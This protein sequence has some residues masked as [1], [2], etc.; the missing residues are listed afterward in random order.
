MD[1]HNKNVF[2]TGSSRGIGYTIAETF[3]KEG[4][5]I[6]LN[7]RKEIDQSL[8]DGITQY[9]VTCAAVNG[10]IADFEQA[11]Q[12]LAEAEAA[13]GPIHIL[14]NNAGIT[15]DKLLLRMKPEDFESVIKINLTGT[16]NMTQHA[17]KKMMKLREGRIINLTSVVGL[18]GNIGQANYAA[19]KA[20]VIGFTKSAAR[21]GAA[22]G[23]TVNAIA[24]G[25]IE[26]EMT[27]VLSD[28]V[29]EQSIAVIPLQRF[30]STED[31]AHAAVFLAKSPYITG[32]VLS[33]D[34]GMAMQG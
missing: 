29:K 6:I 12:M 31:V 18:T 5:N 23:I 14:V 26:T 2:V 19:S 21:E 33:V 32:Q 30:G 8:I 34:G 17:I 25:F 4:A 10:D 1:L 27:A 7:G 9:G 15:N 24:P 11:G 13:I 22:R 3:A 16:F 28:K 20:G